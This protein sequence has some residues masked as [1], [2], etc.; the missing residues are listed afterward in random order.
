VRYRF[1]QTGL[2]DS[3][4]TELIGVLDGG[5]LPE[6]TLLVVGEG[7]TSTRTGGANPFVASPFSK[8]KD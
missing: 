2:S 1:I 3:V 4:N 8:K 7:V 6:N 5:D